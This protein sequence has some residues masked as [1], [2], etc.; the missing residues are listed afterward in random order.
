MDAG[1]GKSHSPFQYLTQ[2]FKLGFL[3]L[4]ALACFFTFNQFELSKYFPIKTVQVYG[5]NHLDQQ[6]VKGML[7]PLVKRSFFTINVEYIRDQ[8]LQM[9]W[10]SETYV[11]VHWP[12]RVEITVIEKNPVASWNGKTLLSEGGELFSP[13]RD[14]FPGGLPRFVG[15]EGM[16]IIMMRYFHE[17]NRLLTPIHAKIAYLEM[18]P[19]AALKATLDNGVTLQMGYKDILTHFSHFVKVYPNIVGDRAREVN[20]IDLRYANGM[21]VR[22]KQPV[23]S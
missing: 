7:L 10:V 8:L 14:S 5:V 4:F 21:A 17:M 18:T 20:Y 13:K 23:K 1:K 12:D 6:D 19:Y 9:P 11:R 22:W 15:P 16:Q 2:S 3:G